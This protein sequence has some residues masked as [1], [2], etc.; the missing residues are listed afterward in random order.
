MGH[1]GD[2]VPGLVGEPS[3]SKGIL[4]PGFVELFGRPRS[5]GLEVGRI[6][7]DFGIGKIVLGLR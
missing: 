7:A 5:E 1:V 3:H 6:N 2:A 4:G